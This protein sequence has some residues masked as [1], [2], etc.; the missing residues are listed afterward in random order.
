MQ[1]AGVAGIDGKVDQ[2]DDNGPAAG[3]G[4]YNH[5]HMRKEAAA[6]RARVVGDELRV[7]MHKRRGTAPSHRSHEG[8]VAGL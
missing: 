5:Q 3:D 1:Q 6:S 7:D 2:V 8:P 4:D